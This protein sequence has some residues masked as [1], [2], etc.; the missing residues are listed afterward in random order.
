MNNVFLTILRVVLGAAFAFSG[1]L[2]LIHPPEE[3]LAVILKFEIVGGQAARLLS[4][5]L[6]W[7]EWV[8]GIFL[9]VGLWTRF[10][11]GVLW[12]LNTVFTAVLAS[13]LLRRL[14]LESCGCFGERFALPVWTTLLIDL[15]LWAGF[16]V[17]ILGMSKRRS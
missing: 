4:V 5:G 8:F 16:C 17:M 9:I 7:V 2:K 15:A 10:A 11:G 1:Y 3:F 6:P 13:V 12:A 14:P